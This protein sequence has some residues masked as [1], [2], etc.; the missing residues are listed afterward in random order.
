MLWLIEFGS[1]KRKS[2]KNHIN[3][4]LTKIF[5]KHAFS[6]LKNKKQK[7]L[8]FKRTLENRVQF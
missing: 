2:L 3:K 8:H 6:F 4:S 7:K 5:L 1:S